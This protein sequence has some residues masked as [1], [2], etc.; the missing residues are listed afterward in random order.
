[1]AEGGLDGIDEDS[2]PNLDFSWLTPG[3]LNW[4]QENDPVLVAKL[5][6]HLGKRAK[7]LEEDTLHPLHFLIE[8]VKELS[9]NPN[10]TASPWGTIDS[11][12][13]AP[14]KIYTLGHSHW[15][16]TNLLAQARRLK[17]EPLYV[18]DRTTSDPPDQQR[19]WEE[20]LHKDALPLEWQ[21]L[22]TELRQIRATY[23]SL[24][25]WGR[26]TSFVSADGI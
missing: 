9:R 23:L 2:L 5:G 6:V 25:G 3:P 4:N 24:C 17:V 20:R 11:A 1:M 26:R 8:R 15:N 16:A 10:S 12:R 22:I 18:F 7:T 14:D 21:S 13:D 19:K